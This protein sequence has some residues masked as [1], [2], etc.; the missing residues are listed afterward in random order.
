M[1][2]REY[3][4]DIYRQLKKINKKYDSISLELHS[5][6]EEIKR[7]NN[8]ILVKDKQIKNYKKKILI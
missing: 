5:A 3:I 8:V 6:K 7:L 4:N 1:I 2:E